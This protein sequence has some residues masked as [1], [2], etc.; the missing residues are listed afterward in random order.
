MRNIFKTLFILSLLAASN[1]AL[2]AAEKSRVWVQFAPQRAEQAMR[3]LEQAGAVV[4][5]RFD[6]LNAVAVSLP[7]EQIEALSKNRNIE[8]IE[9]DVKRFPSAQS[10][11]YGIDAVQARDIW[12]S[13][14]DGAIDT[15]AP[16]GSG[17]LICVIDSGLQ[18]SHTDMA[19]VNVVGG[20]PSGWNNDECGHGTHVAGTI[21]AANNN[22]G[23][24]GVNPGTVSLYIVQ[25]FS[26]TSC[27]WTYSSD[28]VNAANRCDAA[29]A[30][31][32]SMSL[33]GGRKSRTED[34]AFKALDSSGILSIAAAGNDGNTRRSYPA[35]YNSVVSVAAVDSNNVVANFSQKN[36]AVELAAP[37]VGVLST[38][39]WDAVNTLDVGGTTYS[40]SHIEFAALG[41]S[42][43][44]V[45]D[46]GLCDSAGYWD[47]YIVMCQRG[48][49]SFLD[50]VTNVDSG[51]GKAAVIYNNVPGGFAGTLGD[52][53]SS[54]IPAIALS[55]QDGVSA[56][57]GIDGT[58]TVISTFTQ[59]G[60]GYEAW[61][62]TSMATPHVSGVAALV[63]SGSPGASNAD[64]RDA[65]AVTAV[66]LGD[67]G[68]DSAYGYG[69]V[70]AYDAWQYLGGG[71]GSSN[72]AP[73]ASFTS[74]CTDLSCTFDASD[75][76]DPDG[77]IVNYSWNFGDGSTATGVTPSAHSYG[78]DGT[79]SVSLTV[80]DDEGASNTS[81]ASVTV[82]GSGGGG[83][84]TTPPVISNVTAGKTKGQSFAISWTT[85]EAATSMVSFNCCGNFSD[86]ALVTSHSMGFRG[87]KGASYTYLVT[88]TDA[89][90]NT[91]VA[92][93]FP[94]QN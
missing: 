81:N 43:G 86:T 92:G 64:I 1:S 33:G 31:I 51:G 48:D 23:V 52:G 62:G 60:S 30:D 5:H 73:T 75:S 93:P 83:G 15:G 94:Y 22:D 91:S 27:A 29:G 12:D 37:G 67:A 78:G 57:A 55:Q 7:V 3:A 59:P 9:E 63:W 50:K 2:A 38:V 11:P 77:S 16:N 58:G 54:S 34:K 80:T 39:P 13:N 49:I 10:I 61:D 46:G 90:G 85:D 32:I 82:S 69:L 88:S 28:L 14:G 87:S 79:Y 8:L 44:T 36:S 41:S 45:V 47:G 35:S 4:H 24:V 19:G 18:T 26:G 6:G 74:N 53:N 84:D 70:Q 40:G 17:I 56:L 42:S 25:V 71:G 65:L 72:Q 21:T 20:Y 66:D 76:S 89:A 68:R